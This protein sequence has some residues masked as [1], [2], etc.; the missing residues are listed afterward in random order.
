MQAHNAQYT[1]LANSNFTD[2]V[3][4]PQGW[5]EKASAVCQ[6]LWPVCNV[7]SNFKVQ[8]RASLWRFAASACTVG[9]CQCSESLNFWQSPRR[10]SLKAVEGRYLCCSPHRLQSIQ[11]FAASIAR[12]RSA[13]SS[14]S[15]G[16]SSTGTRCACTQSSLRPASPDRSAAGGD[17]A[18]RWPGLSTVT[19]ALSGTAPPNKVACRLGRADFELTV[20]LRLLRD[21]FG[22]PRG[23]LPAGA[24]SASSSASP[25]GSSGGASTT[26]W[27]PSTISSTRREAA[28]LTTK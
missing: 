6:Q 5:F 15:K 10:C 19:A 3:S 9:L 27:A 7:G 25:A 28:R 18:D 23:R 22:R 20:L 26:G 12:C 24:A 13:P 8:I 17:D 21:P 4:H 16:A 1:E 11:A 14:S 2:F